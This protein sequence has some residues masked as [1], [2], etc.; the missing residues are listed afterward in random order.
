MLTTIQ[1]SALLPYSARSMFELVNDVAAYPRYMDGCVAAEVLDHGEGF[2]VARLDLSK[3]G[4]RQSFTTR[5]TLYPHERIELELVDGPFKR[6]SGVWLFKPL[7]DE[8]CKVSLEL[9]FEFD[10][11]VARI[12]SSSLF[13][14]VANHL[15]DAMSRR[16]TTLYGQ[17]A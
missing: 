13:A 17:S 7:A 12:A 16:A 11:L 6:L 1:R 3:G 2:M 15:V 14:H 4:V 9:S 10:N 8:A 5:N